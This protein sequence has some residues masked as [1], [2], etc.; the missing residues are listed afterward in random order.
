MVIGLLAI[1]AIP[2]VTGVGQAVS[3]QKRENAAAKSQEKFQLAV[4]V[5]SEQG[6]RE[7]G[8][9]VLEGGRVSVVTIERGDHTRR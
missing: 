1:A 3:A 4:M 9:C 7:L 8:S 6:F 5:R 2:T